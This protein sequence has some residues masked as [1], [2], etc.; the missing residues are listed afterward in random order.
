MIFISSHYDYYH[1]IMSNSLSLN[2]GIS[3]IIKENIILDSKFLI[4]MRENNDEDDEYFN[5]LPINLLL[6]KKLYLNEFDFTK[7][8]LIILID[9]LNYLDSNKLQTAL[10]LFKFKYGIDENLD[11][12]IKFSLNNII[13]TSNTLIGASIEVGLNDIFEYL[14]DINDEKNYKYIKLSINNLKIFNKLYMNIDKTKFSIEDKKECIKNAIIFGNIE[15]LK[16]LC[17]DKNLFNI[18]NE[19]DYEN[20]EYDY[21]I[22]EICNNNF[23]FLA[24]KNGHLKIL[25]FILDFYENFNYN[26]IIYNN[27]NDKYMLEL[28]SEYNHFDIVKFLVNRGEDIHSKYNNALRNSIKNKNLKISQFLIDNGANVNDIQEDAEDGEKYYYM[29]MIGDAI[30]D[31]NIDIVKFLLNNNANIFSYFLSIAIDN[32]NL[33]MVRLLVENDVNIYNNDNDNDNYHISVN[34]YVFIDLNTIK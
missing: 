25:E 22:E 29:H 7:I 17:D 24:I 15:I 2:D 1:K 27:N 10:F 12:D 19:Y 9:N 32:N 26:I 16:I 34:N 28:A 18:E 11:N 3:K 30:K 14:Y 31:M 21:D 13:F 20:Y 4:N 5:F 6:L 23:A 33:E 8:E